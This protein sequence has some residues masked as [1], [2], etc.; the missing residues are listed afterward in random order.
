MID[1]KS[2]MIDMIM[3]GKYW[4]NGNPIGFLFSLT[5]L[6]LFKDQEN[7]EPSKAGMKVLKRNKKEKIHK[8][9]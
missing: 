2:I 9:H 6:I 3:K 7:K 5:P 8:V 1:I 4:L